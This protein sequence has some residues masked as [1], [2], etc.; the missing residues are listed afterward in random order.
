MYKTTWCKIYMFHTYN[1]IANIFLIWECMH[2]IRC[3]LLGSIVVVNYIFIW[4]KL[5][6]IRYLKRELSVVV[7]ILMYVTSHYSLVNISQNSNQEKNSN[8]N[9]NLIIASASSHNAKSVRVN[10]IVLKSFWNYRLELTLNS[11]FN[12]Q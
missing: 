5:F 1:A 6:I 9:N 10:K 12:I 8:V 11:R 7:L 3:N 4:Y 2:V